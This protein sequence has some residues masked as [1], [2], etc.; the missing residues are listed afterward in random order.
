MPSEPVKGDPE[1]KLVL[2]SFPRFGDEV[3]SM[4]PFGGKVEAILR[5]AGLDYEGVV[6]DITNKKHA[7]KRKVWLLLGVRMLSAPQLSAMSGATATSLS[8]A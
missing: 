2:V 8:I 5:I 4:S 6:G 3:T 1:A 7:P